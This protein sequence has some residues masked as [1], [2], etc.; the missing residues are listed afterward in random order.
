MFTVTLYPSY[1]PTS[2]QILLLFFYMV[3]DT[4]FDLFLLLLI[5]FDDSFK[6]GFLALFV[7][8]H[9]LVNS[10]REFGFLFST[11]SKCIKI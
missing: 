5:I 11:E 10:F 9:L 8:I 7:L 2:F 3:V 4:P 1:H 6:V